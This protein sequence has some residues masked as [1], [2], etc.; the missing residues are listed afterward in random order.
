[1]ILSGRFSRRRKVLLAIVAVLLAWVG[2]AWYT[3]IAITQGIEER[4]MDWN[5]DGQVTR[6]EIWQSFYAVGVSRTQNGPRECSTFYW[7]STGAQIRVDCRTTFKA[8]PAE[9]K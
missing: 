7:R 5:G 6:D 9:K 4:D 3:G 8:A 1:M 2:Y